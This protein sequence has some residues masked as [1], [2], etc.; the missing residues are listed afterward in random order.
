MT[1]Q[2][3]YLRFELCEDTGIGTLWLQ[4]AAGVNKIDHAFGQALIDQVAALASVEGLVGVVVATP[5]R[6]W[7]VGADLTFLYGERDP[8][9]LLEG[10][11]ALTR[12]YR[13]L[14]TLG[15]PVVAALTGSALGG[16]FEL[17][18]A[19]HHRVALDSGRVKLGLPEV[20]LGVIPGAGGTQRLPRLIGFQ[21]AL[22]LITQG[23]VL[24]A[25]AAKAKGLVDDLQ[26]SPEAVMQA[27]RDWI[28]AHPG[29]RAPWDRKG[30][31]WPAPAPDS[32]DA[33]NLFMAGSAMLYKRTAGAYPAAEAAFTAAQEGA[34]LSFE[35][36]LE[37]EARIFVKLA[38]SDGAKDMIRTFFFHKNAADKLE[39][40]PRSEAP[41]FAKIAVLGAGMMGAGLAWICA[42][43][44]YE[45][46]LKDIG[47]PALDRGMAHVG[48]QA[49]KLA[50]KKGQAE[51]DVILARII[52]SLE[53]EDLRGTDLV[54]EAVFED[55]DLKHRVIREVEPLLAPGGV[56]ASN[57][58]AL[59]ITDLAVASSAPERFIGL[60]FF[61][62]VEVMPLLE[63]IQGVGIDPDTVGRCLNFARRIRKT[64][65]VVGD[66][67]GFYTTRVFAAYILEGAQLVAEG[68]E[69]ALIEWAAR[70]AG[71]AVP[72]L[73]V[74]DEI[75]LV[76]GKHVV[77]GSKPYL[78]DQLDI[79]GA[80]LVVR[81]VDDLGRLG[82]THG[83]G[84]YDY[85]DGRR[86]GLWPGLAALAAGPPAET[87]VEHLAFRLL[88]IQAAE[89]ARVY[90]AGLL[91][92]NRDADLGAVLGL[93][94]SPPSGGP[95]AWMDRQG[96]PGLVERLDALAAA[97][98]PRYAPAP[99]LRRM[100]EQGLRF[101]HDAT[102]DGI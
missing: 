13:A 53:L 15:V 34:R 98:G 48:K 63:V 81:M 25:P 64:P 56:F 71:M 19:C 84:F 75:T 95:L 72:P 40:L 4:G 41:D 80:A 5:Y 22:E 35:R 73:Q 57:T 16:G 32:A 46:V 94:F 92:R 97:H 70:E 10:V 74:F 78:G 61:S 17:A 67:F 8:G 83:A 1:T 62:P 14:E 87:G 82:R 20:S 27:A 52:P 49:S 37:L 96:L 36:A 86:R 18:L 60:H 26:A 91:H 43:A 33:R 24:P 68:H 69:P 6:D 39:S 90:D 28:L 55:I 29:H 89:V 88:A 102:G 30:F 7:C 45:V 21:A 54:I 12:S 76:L 100:A 99:V 77:A 23:R 47:Q 93:G 65:I 42:R 9:H 79:P 59:P 51:V 101:Y 66:G 2:D 31:T 50:R 11:L 85:A 3:P 44:G 58:S 38:T